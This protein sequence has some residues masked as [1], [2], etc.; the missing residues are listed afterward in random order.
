MNSVSKSVIVEY[1]GNIPPDERDK[2]I[3]GL[4]QEATRLIE[5]KKS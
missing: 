5:V 4:N 2:V 1:I 3:A